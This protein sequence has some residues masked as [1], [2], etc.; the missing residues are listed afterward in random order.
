M[1][2]ITLLSLLILTLSQVAF[3]QS[4]ESTEDL[5]LKAAEAFEL[6]DYKQAKEHYS[7]LTTFYPKDAFYNY[8]LG[9]CMLFV[10]KNKSLPLK[11]LEYAVTQPDVDEEALFFLGKGY[12]YNYRFKEAATYYRRF[13]ESGRSKEIKRYQVEL[14]IRMAENGLELLKN[15]T[16]PQVLNKS[17]LSDGDFYLA[18]RLNEVKGKVLPV[19]QELRSKIDEREEY[20]GTMY[21]DGINNVIFYSSYGEDKES[22]IDIFMVPITNDGS[23]GTPTKL[24][25]S[26]NTVYDDAFPFLQTNGKDFYFASKGHTSMG[27]YD[28]F[29]STFNQIAFSFTEPRNLDWAINT[30][31][32]DFLYAVNDTTAMAY[33]TS[34]RNNN[35][36]E[37]T[38][39]QIEP[40]TTP[41]TFTVLAGDFASQKTNS[42]KII[43]KEVDTDKEIG[44]F[45][46]NNDDGSY[47]MR[48][49]A[50]TS[51]QFI[52]EPYGSSQVYAGI[53][54]IPPVKEIVTL[55]Q[56]IEI[57]EEN[58]Q[59]RLIIRNLFEK[60]PDETD[61]KLLAEQL[62]KRADLGIPE[63]T[64]PS[65]NAQ[66][67][68]S[69]L[70]QSIE[71]LETIGVEHQ[72]NA[73]KAF[74]LAGQKNKLAQQDLMAIE[75]IQTQID[76]TDGISD[77]EQS[78]LDEMNTLQKEA[79]LHTRQAG[80]AFSLFTALDKLAGET[81]KNIAKA[82]E[83]KKELEGGAELSESMANESGEIGKSSKTMIPSVKQG[84]KDYSLAVNGKREEAIEAESK[85]TK[86]EEEI[87]LL[88]ED[89]NYYKN[90]A[91][92]T[93]DKKLKASFIAESESMGEEL[94]AAK[95]KRE[96][97]EDKAAKSREGYNI[98]ETQYRFADEI[99]AEM[100]SMDQGLTYTDPEVAA[101]RTSLESNEEEVES[102]LALNDW[103]EEDLLDG[104][105]LALAGGTA[106]SSSDGQNEESGEGSG[107]TGDTE[108]SG[109]SEIPDDAGSTEAK[110][111]LVD[112][113]G[114]S[115]TATY[116]NRLEE[117]NAIEND[118]LR[119]EETL[120]INSEWSTS[121][122]QEIDRVESEMANNEAAYPEGALNQKLATLN[123]QAN[124]KRQAIADANNQL[125]SLEAPKENPYT[126]DEKYL[127]FTSIQS[128]EQKYDPNYRDAAMD[129]ELL[130]AEKVAEID[131][132]YIQDLQSNKTNVEQTLLVF[133]A[134]DE[135]YIDLQAELLAIDEVI[136]LKEGGTSDQS[137]A[138]NT[139]GD[140]DEFDFGN[141][142][143]EE[144]QAAP[145]ATGRS[146]YTSSF[147]MKKKELEVL[148]NPLERNRALAG[149]TDEWIEAIEKE[150]MVVS[151]QMHESEQE[152][153]QETLEALKAKDLELESSL[154]EQTE[155]LNTY[156][157]AFADADG[158]EGTT[159]TGT[160]TGTEE[161]AGTVSNQESTPIEYT[162]ETQAV[163]AKVGPAKEKQAAT[164][165]ELTNLNQALIEAD[166]KK[167]RQ[168]IEADIDVLKVQLA[169]EKKE[170]EYLERQAELLAQTETQAVQNPEAPLVSI[171][172][173]RDVQTLNDEI[174][175][176]KQEIGILK[177]DISNEKK[178]KK[179]K[180]MLEELAAKESLLAEKQEEKRREEDILAD[181]LRI[182][183]DV[184]LEKSPLSREILP[185]PVENELPENR[186]REVQ[187]MPEAIAIR[188]AMEDYD[189]RM[190]Q[191]QELYASASDKETEGSN[192]LQEADA[193]EG[194]MANLNA[195]E[196]RKAE[197][198]IE[199]LRS[200]GDQ[201]ISDAA[202][203]RKA[204]QRIERQANLDYNKARQAVADMPDPDERVLVMAYVTYLEGN[205][206]EAMADGGDQDPTTNGSSDANG[207]QQSGSGTE[208]EGQQNPNDQE[209]SGSQTPSSV[210][211][212]E[213]PTE[214]TI[215]SGEEFYSDENPIPALQLPDGLVFKV[216][217]GAFSKAIPKGMFTGFAP[218]SYE[219][220]ASG[221]KRYTAGLFTEFNTA[222]DAK[223]DIRGL[224]YSDA[225]VVAYLDGERISTTEARTMLASGTAPAPNPDELPDVP[226]EIENV[227]PSEVSFGQSIGQVTPVKELP[228]LF[229]TVQIGVYSKETPPGD[230]FNITPIYADETDR[231][232]IRYSS[233]IFNTVAAAI[234]AKNNIV[235]IG[236]P[237]AFVTAYHQGERV[238]VSEARNLASGGIALPE[239]NQNVGQNT[240]QNTQENANTGQEGIPAETSTEAESNG[241]AESG[242]PVGPEEQPSEERPSEEQNGQEE[243]TA[244]QEEN[245]DK[246][247]TPLAELSEKE[248]NLTPLVR[249]EVYRV[250]VGP[251]AGDVPVAEAAVI[252]QYTSRGV[253]LIKDNGNTFYVLGNFG[254][255]DD[256][257][258]FKNDLLG[259]N[260]TKPTIIKYKDGKVVR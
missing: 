20:N 183:Q 37:V 61:R 182:E 52:V 75:Q 85:Y 249:G 174:E 54:N 39:Y 136:A 217:V 156:T 76:T 155:A 189:M 247:G 65:R 163:L 172:Q 23:L 150:Q 17:R 120:K 42:A 131:Q 35:L 31:D 2:F 241:Q 45:G 148:E 223:N 80:S 192:Q 203:D 259:N 219:E 121:I 141:Y 8:R 175:N 146:V 74:A 73:E 56:E 222:N 70:E 89:V 194:N 127:V 242:D 112:I 107:T 21:R 251:Y 202:A 69:D 86:N 207:G 109:N 198:S 84:V 170:T 36:G 97:L 240:N 62:V 158:A 149:L 55:R 258:V 188:D 246:T 256:A 212:A 221:L 7:Q 129:D 117:A 216:Q 210:K 179:R 26:I 29:H 78:L 44:A 130:Q 190:I 153:D 250:M 187:S 255:I 94:Q 205:T 138:Q 48:L 143:S 100:E 101:F 51:Y 213:V 125:A 159:E 199:E 137:L 57:V 118:Y 196:Q 197:Q 30:P 152:E 93:K 220:T 201:L 18:Y 168:A 6:G 211:V 193:L 15:V 88:Q 191:V 169:K 71:K 104:L 140:A 237:D 227:R 60:Q 161:N 63:E 186:I 176:L 79:A 253:K 171:Q 68:I 233:G 67:V 206:G 173:E 145:L 147:E 113:D 103:T 38:V 77:G 160:E 66:Q 180:P 22:G 165:R 132:L 4:E 238:K 28:I 87:I 124:A 115:Y 135:E 98:L 209:D 215:K 128:L 5:R 248:K 34:S 11:Y 134:G 43:V 110:P 184:V 41:E 245:A 58:G 208:S 91:E 33:F 50:N 234:E 204:A 123:V 239:S 102:Y 90:Q 231:G 25:E 24:P 232:L 178:K 82:E 10:D 228:L 195:G 260:M 32:D 12:H 226:I 144:I 166:K 214:F 116:E 218:V 16:E 13:M 177:E 142:D 47:V 181:L 105:E 96:S 254:N 46:T 133:E 243:N 119:T 151:Y 59:E 72:L 244:G 3:G 122:Q 224:G 92:N 106:I 154:S 14:Q 99:A 1:R 126:V 27:G 64:G 111:R 164:E 167:E 81:E 185:L 162:A 49:K 108:D 235:A 252:L 83:I 9:A 200:K 95:Y 139:D 236:I 114:S 157:A 53:V 229:Y 19:P 225:F 40:Q 257:A 230:L